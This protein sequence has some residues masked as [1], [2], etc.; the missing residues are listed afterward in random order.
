MDAALRVRVCKV[1]IAVA[2]A[3]TVACSG[4]AGGTLLPEPVP[5]C[6]EYEKAVAA[7][8][9]RDL[10]MARTPEMMPTTRADQAAIR[11]MC[12]D[13]LQRIKLACR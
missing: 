6:L 5:E 11:G 4:K 1:A 9:H 12:R 7:C 13:N 8:F 10:E 2:L 3:P